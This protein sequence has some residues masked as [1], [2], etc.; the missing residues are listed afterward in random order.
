MTL[1][2]SMCPKWSPL[3]ASTTSIIARC[4]LCLLNFQPPTPISLSKLFEWIF[5]L[6]AE[7]SQW[8]WSC[9][10]FHL[11]EP[12]IWGTTCECDDGN[13]WHLAAEKYLAKNPQHH[14]EGGGRQFIN[15]GMILQ[16]KGLVEGM[17]LL[18][19]YLGYYVLDT[20][21]FPVHW[22]WGCSWRSSGDPQVTSAS[23]QCKQW[24]N[25]SLLV[26]GTDR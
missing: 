25:A 26:F 4:F 19:K 16:L 18:P 10:P 13:R 17:Y 21:K 1:T 20:F 24:K 15:R 7:G 5:M 14:R 6:P 3:V 23:F 8:R 12:E 11:L 9:Q 22:R 2:V